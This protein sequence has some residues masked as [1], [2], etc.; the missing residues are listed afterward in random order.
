MTADAKGRLWMLYDSPA[1]YKRIVGGAIDA[2]LQQ[3]IFSR[4]EFRNRP[5]TTSGPG[6]NLPIRIAYRLRVGQYA[7]ADSLRRVADGL[8]F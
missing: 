5:K 4:S 1:Q 3:S 7:G 6:D 2:V 8:A